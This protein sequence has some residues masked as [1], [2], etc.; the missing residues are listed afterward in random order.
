MK[1]MQEIT[2]VNAGGVGGT[3]GFIYLNKSTDL[4]HL[5]TIH[6]NYIGIMDNSKLIP[7]KIVDFESECGK[8]IQL[9]IFKDKCLI[10]NPKW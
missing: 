10:N 5:K 1:I 3:V 4:W 7:N 2:R 8:A 6:N 9:T